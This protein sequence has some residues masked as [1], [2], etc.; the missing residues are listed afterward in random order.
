MQATATENLT[1]HWLNRLGN[2]WGYKGPQTSETVGNS[3]ASS[4]WVRVQMSCVRLVEVT[5][6]SW[7]G[8][9]GLSAPEAPYPYEF[10]HR[11]HIPVHLELPIFVPPVLIG[12][13]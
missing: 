5:S 1:A 4:G 10:P 9:G 13:A 11:E 7:C 8:Y 6:R 3:V 2:H 12:V